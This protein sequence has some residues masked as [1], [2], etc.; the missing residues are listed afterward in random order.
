MPEGERL[1]GRARFGPGAL[2]GVCALLVVAAL[3]VPPAVRS[4][5]SA[6][7]AAGAGRAQAPVPVV[8]IVFD[9]LPVVSLMDASREIDE[10]LFP[11]FAALGATSTWYRNATAV[12]ELTRGALPSI[13][14]G[15]DPEQVSLSL[16]GRVPE[17]IFT[18]LAPTHDVLVSRAFPTLCSLELCPV[19]PLAEPPADLPLSVFAA[20]ARGR[21][22]LSFLDRLGETSDP[23]LCV[24]HA[25]MP[26]S[27]WRYLP[28]GQQ[29]PKTEPMPGQVEAPG[30]GRRWRN[31]PWL[32]KQAHQRHLL[33]TGFV[34]R[35]LGAVID[36]LH[37]GGRFEDAMVVVMA[38]HGIAFT[39]GELKRAATVATAG[40]VAHV[41][42]FV[43]MPNQ[44]NAE[45]VDAPV[46]VIDVVPTIADVVELTR[47][48]V[49][50]GT[51]LSDGPA[52]GEVRRIGSV[53]LPGDYRALDRALRR[54]LRA[55]P[56]ARTWDDF[57]H[58]APPGG[59][60]WLGRH[61][62]VTETSAAATATLS[63]L[64]ALEQASPTDPVIPALVRGELQGRD[65]ATSETLAVA[66]DG[67]IAALTKTYRASGEERFY[68]LVPPRVFRDPPHTVSVMSLGSDGRWVELPLA[69]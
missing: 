68:A 38:D 65:P 43:K 31:N 14:T 6:G 39:P 2:A 53:D 3:V 11:N 66:I 25:V 55:F 23:C 29:Y 36:R 30:P 9:E 35:L 61:P 46:Q 20:E 51:P 26:H 63:G 18:M 10:E 48:P 12:A 1:G 28:S 60:R 22:F 19:T 44:S 56:G 8:L 34:D 62:R 59:A 4:R 17:T 57:L 21:A 33:Q 54:R 67:R 7:T 15:L 37:L 52:G 5:S 27:P 13:L 49:F 41:P 40:E 69:R 24:L 16:G 58:I 42:L 47:P 45:V 50:D 32:V 64:T